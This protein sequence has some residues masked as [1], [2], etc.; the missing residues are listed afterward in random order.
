MEKLLTTNQVADLLQVKP[1]TIRAWVFRRKLPFVRVGSRAVRFDPH[2]VQ[3]VLKNVPA[4]RLLHAP[5]A[6]AGENGGGR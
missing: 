5:E 3:R 6:P 4:L 1:S 2:A